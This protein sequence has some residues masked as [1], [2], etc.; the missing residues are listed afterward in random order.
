MKKI[1][2]VLIILMVLSSLTLA[3]DF[4]N[5]DWG[6]NMEQVKELETGDLILE[7]NNDLMYS[8]TLVGYDVYLLYR[9]TN[10]DQLANTGYVFD[11]TYMNGNKYID[12][13]DE[14]KSLLTE[15]YGKPLDTGEYWLN[16]LY[17]GD[18]QHYGTAISIGHLIYETDWE[19]DK[20]F[21]RLRLYGEN[22]DTSL[23]LSYMSD[24]YF[25]ILQEENKRS[26]ID[27]L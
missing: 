26:N 11:V 24:E 15:K 8:T 4:R 13:Y 14:I 3:A 27:E 9:F 16:D 20:A 19:A 2:L 7:E 17:K 1:L 25:Q 23:I 18:V 6:M 10:D 22:Y 12:D 5:V 21:I